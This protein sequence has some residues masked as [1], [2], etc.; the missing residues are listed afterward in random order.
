[1]WVCTFS[2]ELHRLHTVRLLEL[3]CIIIRVT[4][5]GPYDRD[6]PIDVPPGTDT[7]NGVLWRRGSVGDLRLVGLVIL[8][9]VAF[10]TVEFLRLVCLGYVLAEV[11][12][13]FT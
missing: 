3:L 7:R 8:R 2:I 9:V 13:K 10:V 11:L 6:I 5:S 1:M 4:G 12:A